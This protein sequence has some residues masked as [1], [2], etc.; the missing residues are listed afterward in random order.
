MSKHTHNTHEKG[1]KPVAS[2]TDRKNIQAMYDAM[3]VNGDRYKPIWDDI[4]K[5]TG[6]TVEPDYMWHN[7]TSKDKALDEFVDDPTS[8]LA[9]N[10]SG[11]YLIGILWGTGEN[12]FDIVP[13]RYV[14]ELAQEA[15]VEEWYQFA[16]DQTLYH[17]NHADAGLHTALRP[18]AYDQMSFGTSGIGCFPNNDFALRLADN[19]LFF[20]HYGID[21]TR[22][23]EGKGGVP[24][25]VSCTYHWKVNRIIGEFASTDGVVDTEKLK[26]MPKAVQNSWR[27]RDFNKE[28]NIVCL[29]FPRSDFDP[30]LKGKRGA[31]YRGVWFLDKAEDNNI[32][33]EEDFAEKPIAMARQIKVRGEVYGRS[34]GTLLISSIRAVNFMVGTTIEILEKLSNPSLG[35]FNNALFGDSVLDSSPNGMTVFNSALAGAGGNPLFPLHDVGDPS[36]II[37]FLIPYLND[38]ITTGFKVDAL[39]DF[40]NQTEMTATESL[41]RSVIRSKSISGMLQQQKVEEMVPLCSRSISV[42]LVLGEL[43]VDPAVDAERAQALEKLGKP[44]RVI[45]EAVL[46]VMRNGRPWF[47][48]KFNNEMEKIMRNEAVQNLLQILQAI[49]AIAALNPKIIHAVNWYKLLKEINDNLDYNSQIL[50][51]EDDFKAKIA[52]EAELQAKALQLQ[53][54]ESAGKIQKDVASAN[55]MNSEA[56]NGR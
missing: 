12:V 55:K 56:Q 27:Q 44:E 4:A 19:A 25:T 50:I 54:G 29:V 53:A 40:N 49:T 32:F 7:G 1:S 6:I 52:A 46:E 39:L 24:D 26:N 36:G 9:V 13:S 41:Q 30:R 47:E 5:Y 33:F 3:K 14:L 51:S 20:R 31:R 34:S 8:A 15:E 43:G 38:K 35:I 23:D 21:N 16:S 2:A 48:L 10:Q 37:S 18:Y 11:D 42:L 17:M 22:I 28:Y 45:P